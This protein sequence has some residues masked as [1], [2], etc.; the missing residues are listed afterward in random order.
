MTTALIYIRQSR[1][2]PRTVSPE[3]QH[4]SCT[5]LAA[6]AACERVEVFQDL[7]LSGGKIAGRRGLQ[8]LLARIEAARKGDGGVTVV[9]AYD[10][11][12]A[13][14]NTADALAF[15]ALMETRPWINVAFVQ[16]TFDRSPAGEFTYTAMAA[17]HAME[18]R[19]A[20]AK[21]RASYAY[22]NAQGTPTGQ[23]PYGY[24][25]AKDG[26]MVIDDE[27]ADVVRRLFTDYATGQRSTTVLA[28]R[29]NTEGIVKP[30]SRS[31]GL[32]W[33]PDTIVDILQN[34]A[35]VGMTYT[36]SRAR[37]E[38]DLIRASWPAIVDQH[39]FDSVRRALRGN[40]R[41][42]RAGARPTDLV[43]S[44]LLICARCGRSMRAHT[45]RRRVYYFC[46]QDVG[47]GSECQAAHRFIREDALLPWATV[48]FER[49]DAMRPDG[50]DA[51]AAA[52]DRVRQSP[53]AIAQIDTSL[54]KIRKLFTWGHIDEAE[55]QR[56]H[57]RLSE[58]RSELESSIRP[59]SSIKL[60]GIGD[61][62]RRGGGA[63]RRLLL[64]TLFDAL[65][66]EGGAI[67]EYVPRKDRAAEVIAIMRHAF[68]A[69]ENVA[70]SGG[71]QVREGRDS[72]PGSGNTRSSA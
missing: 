7:D 3:T 54:E 30:G 36:V 23:A 52:T 68:G 18:R 27:E 49:L 37:R 5:Q 34:V 43:F 56:D 41:T 20:G 17:A 59:P 64:T 65:M 4:Q 21:I 14:R 35:Y 61:A 29:L 38:G 51:A 32:G 58:L 66:V 69:E 46:R 13:F 50:F 47:R 1:H 53:A 48:L 33:V 40:R 10:Q 15:Y 71:V 8:S 19:M 72:N 24:R 28:G 9:A 55:Y 39:L 11:S 44:R 6:V 16:G 67:V 62:W 22:R 63:G 60:T 57:K 12:R 45:N 2:D 42:G 70:A 26:S 31:G 25:R